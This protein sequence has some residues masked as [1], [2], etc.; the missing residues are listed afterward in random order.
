M[1]AIKLL[2][3]ISQSHSLIVIDSAFT[4]WWLLT[5]LIIIIVVATIKLCQYSDTVQWSK[6]F[7]GRVYILVIVYMQVKFII[8]Q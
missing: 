5:I 8:I 6:Y 4:S 1:C 2:R 3:S 7:L